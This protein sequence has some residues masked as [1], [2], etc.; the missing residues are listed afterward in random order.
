[1]SSIYVRVCAVFIEPRG[2]LMYFIDTS[3]PGT[4]E[5][6]DGEYE[7]QHSGIAR[8]WSINLF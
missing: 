2:E 1:M 3:H 6:M 4:R 8:G 7:D 5:D